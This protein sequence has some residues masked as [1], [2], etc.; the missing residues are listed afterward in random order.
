MS[1]F[2]ARIMAS[3]KALLSLSQ[4]V[5]IGE[6]LQEAERI[7]ADAKHDSSAKT[8][9]R[10]ILETVIEFRVASAMGD[11]EQKEQS[12]RNVN[13]LYLMLPSVGLEKTRVT[14]LSRRVAGRFKDS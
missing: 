6:A 7:L 14:D 2:V 13:R 8:V 1:G 4:K 10:E 11:A 12:M 3:D 5:K 9:L